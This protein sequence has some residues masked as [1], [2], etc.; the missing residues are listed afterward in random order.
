MLDLVRK[1]KLVTA[2]ALVLVLYT[3][4]GFFALPAWLRGAASDFVSTQLHKKLNLGKVSFNPFTLA[5]DARDVNLGDERQ[6]T[7]VAV[8][9]LR[10]NLSWS[11]LFHL[12]PVFDE[13]VL[14]KPQVAAVVRGDGSLNLRELAPPS[15]PSTEPAKPLALAIT[16]LQ[17]SDGRVSYQDLSRPTPFTTRIEPINLALD[18]FSTR[19]DSGNRYQVHAV[20][21]DRESFDWAGD[22][23]LNP[24]RSTGHITV[25]DLKAQTIWSYLRDALSFEMP[26]GTIQLAGD[27]DF[28]LGSDAP[29]LKLKLDEIAVHDLGIKRPGGTDPYITLGSLLVANSTLDLQARSVAV[30]SIAFGQLNVN[31]WL[32]ADGRFNLD[33]LRPQPGP[34]P[35]ANEPAAAAAPAPASAPWKISVPR[36]AIAGSTI[37]F[38]DRRVTPAAPLKVEALNAQFTGFDNS[39]HGTLGIEGGCTLSGAGQFTTKGTLALDSNALALNF[40]LKDLDL[41]PLQPYL[42]ERTDMTLLSG[43]VSVAGD[44]SYR[45]GEVSAP[46]DFHGRIGSRDLRT[47]DNRLREDF[48]RW[49]DLA[50]EGIAFSTRPKRLTIREVRARAPYARVIIAPDNSVNISTVLRPARLRDQPA[51]AMAAQAGKAPAPAVAAEPALR[52]EIAKVR[53]DDGSA[54]FADLSIRPNFAAGIQT[55][56][57]TVIGL[58]SKASARAKVDLD[59]KV[60]AYAPVKIEG[61]VN[62]LAAQSYT[63]LHLAFQ[64]MELTTFT[65]YS[66]KFMG[67]T[68]RKGKLSVNF[69]YHVENRKLRAEHNVILDQ[70]T[71]GERVDSPDATKLPVKL[72]IA[73]LKDRNGVIN[74]DLPVTGD[75]DDPKFR[76]GPLIWKVVGNL[77]TKIVT[78]PFKLLGSLFGAG[79]EVKYVDFAA[80]DASIDAA[81][82][83]RIR[84]VAKALN[85]RPE[86][87][88]EIP[89]SSVDSIDRA[90]LIDAALKARLTQAAAG[91]A[92]PTDRG[93]YLRLLGQVYREQF[94]KKPDELTDPLLKSEAAKKDPAAATEA[95]IA[96]LTGELKSTVTLADSDLHSLGQRRAEAVRALLL[97]GTSLD[98]ARVFITAESPAAVEQGK[99][100]MELKLR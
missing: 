57:G 33:E 59:G 75:L 87:E 61:E 1:H 48:I 93:G 36:I 16:H 78:S 85:E 9:H 69:K 14:E 77:L 58:S 52:V 20:S 26:A 73:L 94:K 54:N 79:D 88:I 29:S 3:L 12:S 91:G 2:L 41:K 84:S 34:A 71:L 44:F 15:E 64:N 45:P 55:L 32:D 60:D 31:A 13:I 100:R 7:I 95:A 81:T 49:Q 6:Q 96:A 19:G 99:V 40:D 70:L 51:G 27:Y 25:T 39:G 42:N 22:V 21:V 63:D 83:D 23:R 18:E 98:P 67:Y 65:P 5:L 4:A 24:L 80:G 8:Q 82:A 17:L 62:Y 35:V 53:F 50:V 89:I 56:S 47:I 90:A 37:A 76:L 10:L 30:G 46:I 66:G 72:A 97:E 86:L 68:I 43:F 28:L 11:S 74:I 38:E 92:L